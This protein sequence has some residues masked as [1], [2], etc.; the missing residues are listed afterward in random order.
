MPGPTTPQQGLDALP[1][2]VWEDNEDFF[3]KYLPN[4]SPNARHNL[5]I[6]VT[7]PRLAEQLGL[8]MQN[9][10]HPWNKANKGDSAFIYVNMLITLTKSTPTLSV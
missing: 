4:W 10:S 9:G 5:Q 1:Y 8:P 6:G 7:N 2:K 3:T